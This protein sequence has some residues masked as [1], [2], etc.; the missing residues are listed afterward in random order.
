MGIRA[1]RLEE[2]ERES[3]R[4]PVPAPEA[5]EAP[6]ESA[7]DRVLELQRTAG[8]QTTTTLLQRQAL[9][10]TNPPSLGSPIGSG[11][12]PPNLSISPDFVAKQ[13]EAIKTKIRTYLDS[14]KPV[15]TG[16]ITMGWSMAELVD[17]VRTKVPEATRLPPESIE[18]LLTE[19][20]APQ[21]IAAHRTPG[22]AKGAESELIATVKN[23]FSKIPTE[24]KLERKGAYFQLS[25]SGVEAGYKKDEENKV[26]VGSASGK[27]V[28]VNIAVKG[29]SFA[30]K[31][32]P[33]GDKTK[34]EAGLMFRGDDLVPMLGALGGLFGSANSAIGNVSSELRSG[35][36]ESGRLK[37]QFEPVKEAAEA[38][39]AIAKHTAVTF[40][41]KVEGEGP[42][43]TVQA[44]LTVTF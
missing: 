33:D 9:Q 26:S 1:A 27:D 18:R 32:E 20:A 37:E 24:V 2:L 38:V 12:L 8:N 25:L 6:P 7:V 39:S 16:H 35:K 14:E 10:F 41:V 36:L 5:A 3:E 30:A 23:A 13:D 22:D 31:V 15:V 19:W 40:G 28:A 21:T 42:A 43:V 29:V 44:T 17:L 11:G 4:P 34:W